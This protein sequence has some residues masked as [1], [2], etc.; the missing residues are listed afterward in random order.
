[1]LLGG[2]A[3]NSLHDFNVET[4][5]QRRRLVKGKRKKPKALQVC[6]FHLNVLQISVS[7]MK[8]DR[9][10]PTGT[11]MVKNLILEASLSALKA[12]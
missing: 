7:I 11:R 2:L 10:R 8:H 4:S 5:S 3:E 12:G 9:M 6:V 1:M